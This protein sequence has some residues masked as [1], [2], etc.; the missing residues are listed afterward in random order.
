[1]AKP[2]PLLVAKNVESRGGAEFGSPDVSS[3]D[4]L[5]NCVDIGQVNFRGLFRLAVGMPLAFMSVCD[6]RAASLRVDRSLLLS[7]AAVSLRLFPRQGSIENCRCVE[8][9]GIHG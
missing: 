2:P 4:A 8:S 5:G 1:M 3:V 7:E 6:V 9:G